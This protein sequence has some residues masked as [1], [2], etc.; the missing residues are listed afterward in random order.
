MDQI[1]TREATTAVIITIEQARRSTEEERDTQESQRDLVNDTRAA[2]EAKALMI[3]RKL[4]TDT[5]EVKL[6]GKVAI[7]LISGTEEAT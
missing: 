5:E 2:D 3:M 6:R 4:K 1:H 7:Q